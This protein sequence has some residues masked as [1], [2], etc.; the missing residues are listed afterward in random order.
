M[1]FEIKE[2]LLLLGVHSVVARG[3]GASS[4]LDASAA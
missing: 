4:G 1:L 3:R 2:C